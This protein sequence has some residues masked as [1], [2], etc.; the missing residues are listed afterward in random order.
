V[1]SVEADPR[2]AEREFRESLEAAV[3]DD[4]EEK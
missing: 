2:P 4:G 3:D 1:F